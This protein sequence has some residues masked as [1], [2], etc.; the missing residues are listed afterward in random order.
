MLRPGGLLVVSQLPDHG[1]VDLGLTA[2]TAEVAT[3]AQVVFD[4]IDQHLTGFHKVGCA[5]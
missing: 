4:R 2:Q 5:G 3:V 1:A